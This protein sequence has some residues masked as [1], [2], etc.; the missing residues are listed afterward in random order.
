MAIED[1]G[2]R[3][4]PGDARVAHVPHQAERAA[5]LQHA[6]HLGERGGPGEPMERLGADDRVDRRVGE[7][8]SLR[9]ACQRLDVGMGGDEL[10][11]HRLDRLDG[12]EPRAGRAEQRRELAGAGAEIDDDAPRREAELV[13]EPIGERSGIVGPRIPDRPRPRRRTPSPRRDGQRAIRSCELLGSDGHG[14]P[15]T[16][17]RKPS[18]ARASSGRGSV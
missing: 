3:R 7:R 16:P 1:L 9:L 11:A 4:H 5:R 6:P 15:R 18:Q 10:S 8:Q 17:R 12:D 14:R 2:Q 13:A